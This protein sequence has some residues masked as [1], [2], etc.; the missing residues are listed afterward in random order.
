MQALYKLTEVTDSVKME[1]DVSSMLPF[2]RLAKLASQSQMLNYKSC[3]GLKHS[4]VAV[5]YLN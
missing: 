2:S 1:V 4:I 5:T 3:K